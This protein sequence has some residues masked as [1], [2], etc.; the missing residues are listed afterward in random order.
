MTVE[1][2][3]R[4]LWDQLVVVGGQEMLNLRHECGASEARSIAKKKLHLAAH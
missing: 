1:R 3:V 2:Q 4:W